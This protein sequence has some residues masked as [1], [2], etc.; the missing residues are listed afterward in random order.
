MP[1][2]AGTRLGPYE[3]LAPLGAGGMGEVYRAKDTKLDREVAIK[4]LPAA[5]AQDPERLARFEREA[6]VLASLNHPNIATIHGVEESGGVRA[7]VME[8]VP[9]ESLQGPLPLETALNYAKQIA[10][11]LEAAHEKNIIHRD[12]K[13]A[14]IMITP[15]GVVKVLDFGL[16]SVLNRDREEADPAN[17][18]TL[19]VSP[20]RAGMILGTAGY[21]SPEQARGKAV[22]KRADIWAFG[23]VLYES[24]T[25]RRLFEGETVSDILAHVL[26]KEPDWEQVPA[27]VRRLLEACL[28][29]DP[30]QRLQAIGDWRLLLTNEQ[31]Q[32]IAPSRSRLGWIVATVVFA[33]IAATLGWMHF[34][35]RP[36]DDLVLRL[37]IEPPEGGEF[38][39][40]GTNR[41]VALSPDGK[42]AAYIVKSNGKNQLWVR[43]LNDTTARV[44]PGTE[45]AGFPFWSP[46]SKF[47]AFPA[48]GKL[49]RVDLAGGAPLTICRGSLIRGGT[50]T[51]DG[52]IIFGTFTDGLF[53]VSASGGTP[54]SLKLLGTWP[55]ALPNGHFLYFVAGAKAGNNGVYA[56][57]LA[58][59]S[60]P[61]K[62][63]SSDTS[64]LYAP[65]ANG[66]GYLLWLRGTT[67]LAQELDSASLRL[68]GESH[69]V[70]DPVA[71]FL[72]MV[73][74]SA[75]S[76]GL[77]LYLAAN[78]LQQFTWVDRAGK[79]LATIGEPL[80]IGPFR[81]SP[82]GRRILIGRATGAGTDL[83]L[84]EVE[85]GVTRRL[86]FTGAAY[87]VWSP[88]GRT[89][90]YSTIGPRGLYSKA[91]NGGGAEQSLRQS[92][93]LQVPTDWSRDERF[94]LF[95]EI[96]AKQRELWVLP[97]MPEGRPAANE[98]PK[99]YA[100][101]Q[102]NTRLGRFSPDNRWVAYES[103]ESG[104]YDVYVDSFPEPHSKVQISTAGGSMPAWGPDGRELFYAS[105]D[106][107][108][109]SVSLKAGA[110]SIEPSTPRELFPLPIYDPGLYSYDVA[111]DGQRFLIPGPAQQAPEP[112]TLI[113]NW[114]ALLKK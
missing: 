3:I 18:P 47:I 94:A 35:P 41:G 110:D 40:G 77:L 53:R 22:D 38:S 44:I 48:G 91:L 75:S 102:F 113:V 39:N 21:M 65:G 36:T 112:L 56:V 60:E 103:D 32:V 6:K 84:M 89:V 105:P 99:R 59:P 11:A 13:P 10:D 87:P 15:A 97:L 83:W 49:Q 17:S 92:P 12:L 1:L 37:H 100:G 30:K 66:K 79:R 20:T 5:L 70:A 54:S 25:G 57:S 33:L 24:I 114:P 69:P 4:V 28:Q 19:T 76:N 80:E 46:D 64:A 62:L 85:R 74:A 73:N 63:L 81:L 8:L 101:G 61:V 104:R 9:G 96:T 90:L 29:K 78:P 82:D 98:N 23:V 27:R 71:G 45:D 108:L 14:N 111:P 43:P 95:Y 26:T 51:S 68:V 42:T 109:T 86:S 50:W 88:N 72:D 7:L 31:P 106:N 55:Q 34:G 16:A 52:Q 93:N 58:K 107:M 2:S 67:L